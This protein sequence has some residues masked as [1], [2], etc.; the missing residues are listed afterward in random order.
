MSRVNGLIETE[1]VN[2]FLHKEDSSDSEKS[3]L[4]ESLSTEIDSRRLV[5][6]WARRLGKD[7]FV[8]QIKSAYSLDTAT[9]SPPTV[10]A[11]LSGSSS[12]ASYSFFSRV[13]DS[14]YYGPCDTQNVSGF[15]RPAPSTALP[16]TVAF[17][18]DAP[19]VEFLLSGANE[20]F[21][22]YVDGERLA[23]DRYSETSGSVVY[24]ID[25]GGE[26][27]RLVEIRGTAI[28]FGGAWTEGPNNQYRCWAPTHMQAG[29]LIYIIGD[30]YS[31]GV[32]AGSGPRWW[33]FLSP[34]LGARV[35]ADG[36]SGTGWTDVTTEARVSRM[37][38]E[39]PDL[40]LSAL[41]YNNNGGDMT[42]L[43]SAYED[44]DAAIKIKYPNTPIVTLGP[45]TPIGELVA[46][47]TV[48][49][50]LE[51]VSEDCGN[52][53]VSLDEIVTAYNKGRYTGGD[54]VHPTRL[55][56]KYIGCRA[57]ERIFESLL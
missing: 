11:T 2:K 25:F 21:D 45:W 32:G 48:S 34:A 43:A 3:E 26:G 49:E 10:T 28:G 27:I 40:V 50:A 51:S 14:F 57:A 1:S 19:E 30:S 8:S 15:I 33:E 54:N 47:N 29:P 46:L 52:T 53:Y 37:T 39:T 7:A 41:G 35:W 31:V 23:A 9:A 36:E 20:S 6:G 24:Q 55:G 12:Y 42:A 16:M 44:W 4:R 5:S 13:S 56:H 17:W 18:T 38:G 22:L